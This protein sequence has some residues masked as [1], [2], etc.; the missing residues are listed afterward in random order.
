LAKNGLEV[1]ALDSSE[2]ALKLCQKFCDDK[3]NIKYIKEDILSNYFSNNL[4]QNFDIVFSDGLLEHF[5]FNSQIKILKN[6]AKVLKPG[7]KI[8]TFVPNKFSPWQ[9]IRPFIL[10]GI[11]E[12]PMILKKLLFLNKTSGLKVI[13]SGGINVLPV[14][15][16]P[17]NLLGSY[18]G[19]ILYTISSP[20]YI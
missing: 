7:G 10:K 3:K 13:E 9:L 8:V 11:Y 17:E 18:L 4:K 19:M 6:F 1:T 15:F 2:T 12:E 5:N 16:S 20:E 14:S